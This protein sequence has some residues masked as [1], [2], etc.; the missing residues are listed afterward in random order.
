MINNIRLMREE[1]RRRRE[2]DFILNRDCGCVY[3]RRYWN[4]DPMH[5]YLASPEDKHYVLTDAKSG[6]QYAI[7]EWHYNV[8]YHWAD[9]D[10]Q[11][12]MQRF[13]DDYL[14]DERGYYG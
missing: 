5:R 7:C 4:D 11:E 9:R 6:K 3:C 2:R 12:E 8:F 14:K 13:L 10:K 1:A